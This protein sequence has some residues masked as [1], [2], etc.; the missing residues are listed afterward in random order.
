MLYLPSNQSRGI[1]VLLDWA[2]SSFSVE[3]IP[4]IALTKLTKCQNT[5]KVL[6]IFDSF[7]QDK[8]TMFRASDNQGMKSDQ[9][10][11]HRRTITHD[12]L[13][14]VHGEIFASYWLGCI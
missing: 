6:N 5:N 11:L 14:L 10:A 13:C 9:E 4:T 3:T 1:P 2:S 7:H 8:I 12:A